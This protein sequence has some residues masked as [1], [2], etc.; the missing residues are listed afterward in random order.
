MVALRADT[1]PS[2]LDAQTRR[3]QA[4]PT[5]TGRELALSELVKAALDAGDVERASEAMR[6]LEA[7]RR[8]AE[9][10]QEG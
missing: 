8:A 6:D 2:R 1:S 3:P 7:L 4:A 10:A 9:V 5:L